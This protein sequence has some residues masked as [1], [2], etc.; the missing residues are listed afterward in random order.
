LP[1]ADDVLTYLHTRNFRMLADHRVGLGP[2]HVLVG[3]NATGKSTFFAALRLV[4]EVIERGA[5]EATARMAASF[6]DL[7][8]RPGESIGFAVGMRVPGEDGEAL[9]RYELQIG[10]SSDETLQI[11]AER[12]LVVSGGVD[13]RTGIDWSTASPSGTPERD[14]VPMSGELLAVRGPDGTLV[15]LDPLERPN[16]LF[17]LRLDIDH[18][19]SGLAFLPDSPGYAPA[20]AARD[21]LRSGIRM[22]ELDARALRTP[23]PPGSPTT[24]A[25]DGSNLPHVVRE[26]QRRD[27]MQ[28]REWVAHLRTGVAALIDI[29]VWE[30]PED[31]HL[32]LRARFEGSREAP[33]PSWLLSDGTLRLMA[34]T[35]V[36]YAA[37]PGRPALVMIEEPENGL[38]PLA[39]QAAYDALA[40]PPDGVQVLCATHS[41]IF[42]A[43]AQLDDA[44]VFRRAADG[45]AIVRG[46]REVP[47]LASWRGG[48]LAD[49]FVTGVLS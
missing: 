28:F 8:F 41:P 38:H 35:L 44:L 49:L 36:S 43:H 26:L 47:E 17:E 13:P 3:Q 18:D 45:T 16:T 40:H 7:C 20:R 6:H 48:N 27:P 42:I 24:L 5:R 30:R 46:G 37:L 31:R 23:S 25:L 1:G 34:L 21:A 19:R 29:E 12:L 4:A 33:V 2:F 22:L 11:L 10:L 39:I 15:L 32:V 9:V 14:D